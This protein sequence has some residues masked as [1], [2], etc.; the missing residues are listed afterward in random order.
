MALLAVLAITGLVAY[1][2]LF[3]DASAPAA[4]PILGL[5][6][7]AETPL[8]K[9]PDKAGVDAWRELRD[10]PAFQNLQKFGVWPLPLSPKG[11]SDP[12]IVPPP[13]TEQE[14]RTRQP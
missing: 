12:F 2:G 8:P 6:T 3:R 5:P 1:F 11:R 14:L 4:A 10:S 9:I 7:A 13:V